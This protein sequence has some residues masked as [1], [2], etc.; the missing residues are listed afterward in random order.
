MCR[1]KE[2]GL[3]LKQCA[4]RRIMNRSLRTLQAHA[5]EFD[6]AFPDYVPRKLKPKKAA[7]P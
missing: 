6:L 4:D 2:K 1:L 7:Q 3:T 5:R